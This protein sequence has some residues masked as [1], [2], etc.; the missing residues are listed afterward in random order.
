MEVDPDVGED[1]MVAQV[2][3]LKPFTRYAAYVQAYKMETQ[4][5]NAAVTKIKFFTTRPYCKYCFILSSR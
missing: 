1:K 4:A 5:T 3:G 2:Q